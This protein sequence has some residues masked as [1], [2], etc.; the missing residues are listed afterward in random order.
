MGR[1]V[2]KVRVATLMPIKNMDRALK[3]YTKSLGA[4]LRT[5]GEGDMKDGWPPSSSAATGFG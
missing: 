5:R 2:S 1:M 3:F 4:K